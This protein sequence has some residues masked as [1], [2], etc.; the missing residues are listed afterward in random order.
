MDGRVGGNSCAELRA[1]VF[2]TFGLELFMLIIF[3]TKPSFFRAQPT[4]KVSHS[5]TRIKPLEFESA[6]SARDTPEVCKSKPF[7]HF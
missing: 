7:V 6:A 1:I 3:S 2:H 5:A 4:K